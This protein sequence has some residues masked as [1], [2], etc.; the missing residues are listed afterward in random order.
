ML[1][2]DQERASHTMLGMFIFEPSHMKAIN[3]SPL[4]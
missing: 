1:D 3:V 4:L 2:D